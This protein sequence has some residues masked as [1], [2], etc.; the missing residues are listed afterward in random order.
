MDSTVKELN[1]DFV[2]LL[3]IIGRTKYLQKL[4]NSPKLKTLFPSKPANPR[5]KA[6]SCCSASKKQSQIV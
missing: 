6:R 1:D 5:L 2:V 3:F 4:T